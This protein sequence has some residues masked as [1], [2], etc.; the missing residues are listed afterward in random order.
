[1]DELVEEGR[2]LGVETH[3][4]KKL[5]ILYMKTKE[6]KESVKEMLKKVCETNGDDLHLL[7]PALYVLYLQSLWLPT[8]HPETAILRKL[9]LMARN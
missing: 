6:W 9:V 2:S 7:E 4:L 8:A 5:E 1:M 3:E